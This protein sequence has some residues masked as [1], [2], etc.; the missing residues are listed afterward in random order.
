VFF[1]QTCSNLQSIAEWNRNSSATNYKIFDE[2]GTDIDPSPI[3]V[4]RFIRIGLYG[5]GKYDW[6]RVVEIFDELNEFILKVKPSHDPTQD[7]VD[8][9]LIS[10]F[11]WTRSRE[12][13]LR[14]EKWESG[15][16]L[17]YRFERKAKYKIYRQLDR[18]GPQ[19]CD[20]K[21]RLLHGLA[22]GRVEAVCF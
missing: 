20:R 2:E 11:F 14:T 21:R 18:I 1:E 10:H 9:M 4:G 22:K 16:V 15:R 5:S 13:L 3:E 19:R 7:P 6:V 17:R 12:Q 8:P